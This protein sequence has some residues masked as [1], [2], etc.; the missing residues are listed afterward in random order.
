M[1][2]SVV[3]VPSPAVAE[4]PQAGDVLKVVNDFYE[5]SPFPGFNPGKYETRG[6]LVARA[7]WYAKRID[8]EIPFAASV[9]VA[10]SELCD[11]MRVG[12]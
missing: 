8:A 10:A 7:S 11:W 9:I 3:A 1:P 5:S 2:S 12:L 6:D 4:A